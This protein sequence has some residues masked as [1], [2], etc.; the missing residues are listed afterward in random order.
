MMRLAWMTV[1]IAILSAGCSPA[2]DLAVDTDTDA[3]DSSSSDGADVTT[4]ATTTPS[5]STTTTAGS[6]TTP[7]ATDP[8]LDPTEGSSGGESS[9]STSGGSTTSASTGSSGGS[10]TGGEESTTD[11]PGLPD[12][13]Q[14]SVDDECA[15]EH[16]Y[17][18]GVLGGLCGECSSDADC[19]FGCNAPNPL[20]MPPEGSTCSEGNLGENCENDDGCVGLECVEVINVPGVIEVSSCSEC[21]VDADCMPDQNCNVDISIADFDG[22]WTCVP[23]GSVPLGQTCDTSGSGDAAC[24]SGACAD[25]NIMGLLQIGVC[26]QCDDN[27]DCGPGE[28]CVD[29]EISLD[30]SITPGVCL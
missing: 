28:T 19:E 21:D 18:A 24:N 16:C 26:S 22:V 10:S 25:A 30:G 23:T 4:T 15:S 3:G 7:T 14:C 11:S 29:P 8:T 12:G 27:G 2:I 13:E 20:A 1:G 5:T 9:G 6:T 17:V